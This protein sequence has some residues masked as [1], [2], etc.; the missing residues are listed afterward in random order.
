MAAERSENSA[1]FRA[2]FEAKCVDFLKF[3]ISVDHRVIE[4][5]EKLLWAPYASK[6]NKQSKYLILSSKTVT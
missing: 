3:Q 5:R 6:L 2:I 4:D 1:A